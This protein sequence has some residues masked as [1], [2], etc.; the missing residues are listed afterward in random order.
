MNQLNDEPDELEEDVLEDIVY[1]EVE[2]DEFEEDEDYYV[3]DNF[4]TYK[5]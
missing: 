1:E 3:R 5:Y 4:G 2:I